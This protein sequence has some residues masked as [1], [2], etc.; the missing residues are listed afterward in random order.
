MGGGS[1]QQHAIAG[2]NNKSGNNQSNLAVS[3]NKLLEHLIVAISSD[4]CKDNLGSKSAVETATNAN[5][6]GA[7]GGNN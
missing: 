2:G 3:K 6:M 4:D 1:S 5:R 7:V